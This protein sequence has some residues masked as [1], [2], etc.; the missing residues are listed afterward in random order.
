MEL[1]IMLFVSMAS[2]IIAVQSISQNHWIMTFIVDS[3]Q[4]DDHVQTCVQTFCLLY[5]IP[6]TQSHNLCEPS[7]NLI[8]SWVHHVRSIRG[9]S[10]I[11]ILIIFF[12]MKHIA[13]LYIGQSSK[14]VRQENRKTR[15]DYKSLYSTNRKCLMSW[16]GGR[17]LVLA[18]PLHFRWKNHH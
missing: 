4:K 9:G 6:H 8:S 2:F 17:S 3:G 10:R 7:N 18:V 12:A 14:L 1:I 5:N 11:F 15:E 13:K 16:A